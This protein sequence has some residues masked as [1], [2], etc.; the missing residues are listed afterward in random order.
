M[1]AVDIKKI[2][3]RAIGAYHRREQGALR[4]LFNWKLIR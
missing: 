2:V 4:L 1:V 3:L